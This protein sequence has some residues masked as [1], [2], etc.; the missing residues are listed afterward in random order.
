[1]AA[2]GIEV[3]LQGVPELRQ[4]MAAAADTIRTK[5]VRAALRD[6]GR[7]I[8]NQAR[9][10]A[11]VLQT[12]RPGRKP[13]TVKKAIV[14]RNSKQARKGGNEG[15]YVSV[16]PLRGTRQKKLGKAGALNPNDPYYWWFVEFGTRPHVIRARGKGRRLSI[17][18]RVVPSVQ[19]PGVKPHRFMTRAAQQKDVEAVE[20]FMKRVVPQIEKLNAR[21]S[22]VR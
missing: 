20:T 13:G 5:A 8:Q 3:K 7:V 19:H 16:R 4:A 21:A 10:N 17:G 6:A 2:D 18:G 14:V 12:A 1:M 22:R 15:V 11:P 9:A